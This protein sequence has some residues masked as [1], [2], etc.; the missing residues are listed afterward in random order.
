VKLTKKIDLLHSKKSISTWTELGT[1]LGTLPPKEHY[2]FLWMLLIFMEE[3]IGRY[4]RSFQSSTGKVR[5]VFD[6]EDTLMN[7]AE[8]KKR[9]DVTKFKF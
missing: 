6:L 9:L 4:A 3:M 7:Y 1:L 5:M 2:F 8:V